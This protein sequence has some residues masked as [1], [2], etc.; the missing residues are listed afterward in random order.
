MVLIV[1]VIIAFIIIVQMT[2][3]FLQHLWNKRCNSLISNISASSHNYCGSNII[4]GK[5]LPGYPTYIQRMNDWVPLA[6]I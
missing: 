3:L 5:C 1:C 6:A 2:S 4:L